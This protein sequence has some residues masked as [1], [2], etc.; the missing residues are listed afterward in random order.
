[1]PD[2]PYD[3]DAFDDLSPE[4]QQ[5]VLAEIGGLDRS[6]APPPVQNE[7]VPTEKHD[8]PDDLEPASYDD[9]L[10][11]DEYDGLAILFESGAASYDVIARYLLDNTSL[12][13][14]YVTL[15]KNVGEEDE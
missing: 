14:A 6:T 4:E 15:L 3:R 7:F 12:G 11:L 2:S 13:V 9:V 10:T 5:R 8:A 1:M